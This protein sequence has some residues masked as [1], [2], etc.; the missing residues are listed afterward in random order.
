MAKTKQQKQETVKS[1]T[2]KLLKTKSVVFTNFDGLKVNDANQLRN[3][4]REHNV[5]YAVVKRTL[6]KLAL[7]EAKIKDVDIEQLT[8]GL[9]IAFGAEDEIMP[10]KALAK[11]SKTH[12]E[13]KLVGGI[14]ENEFID[15]KKVAELASLPG[16]EEL[17]SKMVWLFN[18]PV[19]GFVNVLAG[20]IKNL[21]YALNAIQ[22]KKV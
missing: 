4:L 2:E 3:D 18:Y 11:F 22:E 8:G 5:N 20:N 17:L 12:P 16:R 6:F 15:A 21:L 19:S 13:L 10:A 9:G 14:F 7:K 1:L